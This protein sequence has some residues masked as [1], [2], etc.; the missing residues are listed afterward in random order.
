M[1]DEAY[2]R[3]GNKNSDQAEPT[4]ANRGAGTLDMRI[5]IELQVISYLLAN[6]STPPD[7]LRLIRESIAASIT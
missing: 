3:L 2:R 5:L 1:A 4:S 7:D 6:N